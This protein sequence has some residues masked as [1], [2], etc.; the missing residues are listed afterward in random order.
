MASSPARLV[1]SVV[2]T[3]VVAAAG[4]TATY[5]VTAPRIA[6]QARE[7]EQAALAKVLRGASRFEPVSKQLLSRAQQA[8]SAGTIEQ[9]WRATDD[10]GADVGWC[11]RVSA[12]GYGGPVHMVI[13]LDRNGK[14]LGLTILSMNETP[15]LGTRVETEEWFLKQFTELPAGYGERDV[16]KLDVISGATRSSRAVKNCVT[17]AAQ[18]LTVMAGEEGR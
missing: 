11:V 10:S 5:T 9:V 7:A 2:V 14:V 18:A 3:C 16:K 17:A 6:A 8:A 13:G 12:R 4:L 1:A 15:G